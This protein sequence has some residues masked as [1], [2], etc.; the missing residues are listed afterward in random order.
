MRQ[1]VGGGL[2]RQRQVPGQPPVGR[3]CHTGSCAQCGGRGRTLRDGADAADARHEHHG[4]G[5][6]L[7]EQDLL[8]S[9]VQRCIH[10][11]RL[12]PLI[13]YLE[14]DLQVAFDAVER[15]DEPSGHGLDRSRREPGPR[16]VWSERAFSRTRAGVADLD[17]AAS[18]TNH[19]LGMSAGSPMGM[20]ASFGVVA[21]G[22]PGSSKPGAV[23]RM[24]G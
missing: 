5:R 8:E 6:I 7:A 20:P 22:C 17:S 23:Q 12:H 13:L 18:A 10:V 3:W 24:Q 9:T 4:I 19:A 15:P 14:T 11:R 21:K 16:T 2:R 1:V